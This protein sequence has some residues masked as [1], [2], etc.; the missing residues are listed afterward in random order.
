MKKTILF[1]AMFLGSMAFAQKVGGEKDAHGCL[2][3]A[4]YSYSQIKNDCIRVF[5]QKIKL[6]GVKPQNG[7]S[8]MTCVIFSD[9]KKKRKFIFRGRKQV[10]SLQDKE[11]AMSGRTE[12]MYWFLTRKT[13]IRLKKIMS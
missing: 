13:A 4:G 7:A 5:E 3:S 2:P 1:G 8:Y 11:M 12:A 9:D 10:L 6:K